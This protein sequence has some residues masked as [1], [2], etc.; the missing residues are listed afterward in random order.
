MS[1]QPLYAHK[2]VYT[3]PTRNVEVYFGAENFSIHH[4]FGDASVY[5]I[6][7]EHIHALYPELTRFHPAYI[8]TPGERSKKQSTIDAILEAML[9]AQLGKDVIVLGVGGGVVSD[10][11]GFVSSIFKRGTR[12]VLLPTSV[13]GMVDAAL[14]G[15]NGIDAGV[16]KNMIG[17]MYQPEK[18]IYDFTF[19][20]TLP[21]AEWVNG[22]AEIIKHGCIKD[23]ELFEFLEQHTLENFQHNMLLAATLIERNVDLKMNIVTRDEFDQ[24]D[25]QL[26]NFGHTIGHAL[27]NLHELPHGAAIS[28]G[29]VAAC[30]LSERL[31]DL[32]FEEAARLVRLLT[33]YHLPVDIETDHD[34]L[35]EGICM[36]KKRMGEHM[37]FVLMNTI[38][39]AFA[40]PVPMKYI[41]EHLKILI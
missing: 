25:R 5:I 3:F 41:Q 35:F 36:D 2:K 9:M 15:K 31:A 34:K 23:K 1:N 6:T 4:W 38:G 33:Q 27:E 14:G 39:S 8:I 19:L 26:L 20:K 11:A 29:M 28:I 18:I 21:H 30:V 17:T 13:L 37:Q 22:F 16:F 40:K 7:D 12:L 24:H 32:H 10:I